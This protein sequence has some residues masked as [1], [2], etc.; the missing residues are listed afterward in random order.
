[1]P[2]GLIPRLLLTTCLAL[3]ITANAEIKAGEPQELRDLHYGEALFQ[4]YQEAYFPAIV[5]LLSA[6]KQ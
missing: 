6:R 2:H 3:P 4:L 1:M 5:R